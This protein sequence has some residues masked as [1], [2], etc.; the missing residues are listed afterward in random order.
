MTE[1]QLR[2][3]EKVRDPAEGEGL[4]EDTKD[5]IAG[6]VLIIDEAEEAMRAARRAYDHEFA[7]AI[8]A[9][10]GP[11]YVRKAEATMVA[12]PEREAADRAEEAFH[13]AEREA[14]SLEKELFAWQSILN[15]VR[16]MW[17]A[18]GGR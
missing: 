6:A 1:V 9:A 4:I 10:E 18:T 8:L 13:H 16:S 12:M 17:N 15:S 2:A 3:S 11:E 7:R 5:R 14:R